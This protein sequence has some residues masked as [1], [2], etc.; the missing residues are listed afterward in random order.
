M[1]GWDRYDELRARISALSDEN[2]RL[3]QLL[4]SMYE[5][6]VQA[7]S[8]G[9]APAFNLATLHGMMAAVGSPPGTPRRQNRSWRVPLLDLDAVGEGDIEVDAMDA[10]SFSGLTDYARSFLNLLRDCG[11]ITVSEASS[12][13]GLFPTVVEVVVG[14]IA[15]W[16]R[17]Q[18]RPP[19]HEETTV[20]GELA[21]VW[22]DDIAIEPVPIVQMPRSLHGLEHDPVD[23]SPMLAMAPPRSLLSLET[24]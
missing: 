2:A 14:D 8:Q 22:R 16:A 15:R 9:V 4:T 3:K 21:W 17:Q 18:R 6:T 11:L 7:V 19:P 20:S 13:L 12:A 5:V 23:S 24:I 10:G 1:S